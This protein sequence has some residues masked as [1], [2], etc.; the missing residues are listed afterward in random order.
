MC[1]SV[2]HA[3]VAR[4]RIR[5]SPSPGTGTGTDLTS[6]PSR[7]ATGFVLTTAVIRVGSRESGVFDRDFAR[8]GILLVLFTIPDFRFP[9]PAA[10]IARLVVAHV[11]GARTGDAG[12]LGKSG[13]RLDVSR[14]EIPGARDAELFEEKG[15]LLLERVAD[16][17]PRSGREVPELLFEPP[18]RLLAGLVEKLT[19]GLALLLL[20]GHFLEEPAFDLALERQRQNGVVINHVLELGRE[21]DLGAVVRG[22]A[23]EELRRQRGRAVLD[24]AREPEFLASDFRDAAQGLEID[25]NALD[26]S[27][28][29][30]HSAVRAAGL[31]RH[32]CDAFGT[33]ELPMV[34]AH[35]RAQLV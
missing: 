9:I 11:S 27:V 10:S 14:H 5:T 30:D 4:T 25:L 15:E 35:V 19:L 6:V 24:R 34:F 2:P 3:A 29:S 26:G 13:G 17:L 23:A 31:H 12:K 8:D 20:V 32:F 21:V 18:D 28:R 1:R 33:A 22:E 16:R 7:P